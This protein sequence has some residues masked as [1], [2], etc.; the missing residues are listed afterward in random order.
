VSQRISKTWTTCYSQ[1]CLKL[2]EIQILIRKGLPRFDII[3]LPQNMIREG[4]DRIYAALSHLGIELPSE[5]VLVSLNPGDIPK[6]GSHFDL[7]IL[8]GILKGLGFLHS[9]EEKCFYWGEVQLDGAIRPVEDLLGHLLFANQYAAQCFVS[10][11]PRENF[12]GIQP[13]MS[14]PLYFIQHIREALDLSAVSEKK[15]GQIENNF[16][17]QRIQKQWV[18]ST[19]QDSAWNQ[20]R[21]SA[22]QFLFWS[23]CAFGRHHVLLEGSPSVGKTSWCLA[24]RDLQLPLA[25]HQWAERFQY[26]SACQKCFNIQSLMCPPFEAPHH[27]SSASSIIGGGSAQ[28]VAGAITRANYGILFLDEFPEFSRNVLESLREPLETKTITIA[29]RGAVQQLPADI[30]LLCAMN[31]C[32]CGK[33]RSKKRCTCSSNDFWRYQT[34][35]SEPVRD[36]FHWRVWWTYQNENRSADFE[37]KIVRRRLVESFQ[38]SPP[39]LGHLFIPKD[40]SPRRQRLWMDLLLSWGRWHG[41]SQISSSD[42]QKLQSF[43][44]R[45]ENDYVSMEGNELLGRPT[46]MPGTSTYASHLDSGRSP[47]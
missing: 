13:Y 36:R 24:L 11:G 5:K 4:K 35:I 7:P 41:V 3:G 9:T 16:T 17:Q 38:Q 43:I 27:T 14:S 26:Q 15:E 39:Q 44:E 10:A 33:Y 6:E 23:L 40:L 32:I 29:R 34:K 18:E 31:P 42:N 8:V 28:V 12:L 30:Q 45:M 2:V 1:G 37:L 20:L 47:D 19:P 46:R 25:P 22:D 21:G